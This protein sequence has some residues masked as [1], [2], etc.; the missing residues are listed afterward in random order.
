MILVLTDISSYS[1]S[2]NPHHHCSLLSYTDNTY[3]EGGMVEDTAMDMQVDKGRRKTEKGGKG[4][5]MT[6]RLWQGA[7]RTIG[8]GKY[9]RNSGGSDMVSQTRRIDTL[10]HRRQ[11]WLQ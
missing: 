8:C 4:D 5:G 2:P 3:G 1:S 11:N 9:H 6:E 10:L 7:G